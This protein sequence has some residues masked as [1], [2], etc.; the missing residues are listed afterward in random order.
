MLA[1]LPPREHGPAHVHAVKDNGLAVIELAYRGKQQRI[2]RVREMRASDV[3][4][5]SRLV[6]AHTAELIAAWRTYHG[7]A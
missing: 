6:E 4:A 1:L 3:L 5:A 7:E 2:K